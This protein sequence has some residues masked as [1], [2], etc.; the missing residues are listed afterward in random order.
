[1]DKIIKTDN[2]SILF[3]MIGLE[4]PRHPL[5]GIPDLSEVDHRN[6]GNVNVSLGFEYPQ[7]FSKLFK[8]KTGYS[9]SEYRN[10]N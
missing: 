5:V 7:H 9:P 3:E 2:L 8:S 1:M 6:F 10:L 4:K